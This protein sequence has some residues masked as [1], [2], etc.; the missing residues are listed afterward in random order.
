M[1]EAT[2]LRSTISKE[3]YKKRLPGLRE[4]LLRVQQE[5]RTAGRSLAVVLLAGVDSAGRSETANLLNQ[6]MDPRWIVTRSWRDSSDE[7]RERPEFW[8]SWRSDR[9]V[10]G[11]VC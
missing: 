3:D 10:D 8:R 9:H 11:S 5:L 6:W 1:F 2:A 7:E 4:S